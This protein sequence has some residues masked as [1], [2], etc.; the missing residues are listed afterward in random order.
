MRLLQ[1]V[2]S[3]FEAA[4]FS[5]RTKSLVERPWDADDD[6]GADALLARANRAFGYAWRWRTVRAVGQLLDCPE[7]LS[8]N[9]LVGRRVELVLRSLTI[10]VV[11]LSLEDGR[12]RRE[13]VASCCS[14]CV[15]QR[16]ELFDHDG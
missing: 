10:E 14:R 11:S 16:R 2:L 15:G 4:T 12:D 13:P 9:R 5:S 8:H 3:S 6:Y 7:R 1:A